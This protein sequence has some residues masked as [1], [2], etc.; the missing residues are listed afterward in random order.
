MECRLHELRNRERISVAAASKYLSNLVYS[1]KGMGLSMVCLNV[2]VS[3][4]YLMLFSG[5]D[6]LWLGQD[7]RSIAISDTFIQI[8]AVSRAPRCSTLIQMGVDSRVI[9]FL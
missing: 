1:Y 6:D 2:F 7:C 5:Y 3:F 4:P 8:D 9:S